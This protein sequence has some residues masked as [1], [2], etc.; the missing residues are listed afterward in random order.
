[1]P[2]TFRRVARVSVLALMIGFAPVASAVGQS[3]GEEVVETEGRERPIALSRAAAQAASET[4]APG[5]VDTLV[6]EAIQARIDG[7]E[8]RRAA[9]IID[10]EAKKLKP[11]KFA[12]QPELAPAGPVEIVVSIKAQRAYIYRDD[13]LIGV[14]TVSTGRKGNETP[15]GTFPI[16]QKKKMHH[17]NLYNNAPMPFMQ[18]MTWD[19]VA[20]HAGNIPGVPASH[21]CVRLPREFSELL[22]KVTSIGSVVHVVDET[23]ASGLDA[24]ADARDAAFRNHALAAAESVRKEARRAGGSA[25]PQARAR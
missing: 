4:A 2:T 3:T 14:T 16:L 12:W 10:G 5:A 1:M 20:L 8:D 18:R 23:P 7:V 22:F 21:G 17:S 13:R 9:A 6:Q 25:S 19:G 24:L 11:G 15:T